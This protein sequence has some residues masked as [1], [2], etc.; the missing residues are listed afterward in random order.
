MGLEPQGACVCLPRTLAGVHIPPHPGGRGGWPTGMAP[1]RF[2]LLKAAQQ[3]SIHRPLRAGS[4]QA[5]GAHT[6]GP[7]HTCIHV[8]TP[9]A[10]PGGPGAPHS[11]PSAVSLRSKVSSAAWAA[12][13][14]TPCSWQ[15]PG[16]GQREEHPPGWVPQECQC[17]LSGALWLSLASGKASS[18]SNLGALQPLDWV[19]TLEDVA[20]TWQPPLRAEEGP[21]AVLEVPAGP[22]AGVDGACPGPSPGAQ[23]ARGLGRGWL[24]VVRGVFPPGGCQVSWFK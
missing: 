18:R 5:L 14:R 9:L 6:G 12:L 19:G 1:W 11:K 16:H 7:R 2:S 24:S 15:P 8:L 20:V 13:G 4:T 23:A 3:T 10:Q 22:S 21:P 17:P